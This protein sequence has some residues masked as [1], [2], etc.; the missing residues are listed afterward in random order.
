MNDLQRSVPD[1]APPPRQ[2]P[3]TDHKYSLDGDRILVTNYFFH[4]HQATHQANLRLSAATASSISLSPASRAH[5]PTNSAW[6]PYPSPFPTKHTSCKRG[7]SWTKGHPKLKFHPH[8]QA[9]D[10]PRA[11]IASK[12]VSASNTKL[13]RFLARSLN[14]TCTG[15]TFTH[16]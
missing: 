12:M 4:G 1:G 16:V 8:P 9:T 11:F 2:R 14:R 13:V 10:R 15:I 7:L 6:A 3:P 5:S